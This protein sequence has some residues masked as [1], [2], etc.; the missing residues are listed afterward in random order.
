MTCVV[1][2]SNNR[3]FFCGLVVDNSKPFFFV[4]A[5]T[6]VPEQVLSLQRIFFSK[7]DEGVQLRANR[8]R[9][10]SDALRHLDQRHP[11]MSRGKRD[12]VELVTESPL[13]GLQ[14]HV[15]QDQQ[16]LLFLLSPSH[17][18]TVPRV[19]VAVQTRDDLGPPLGEHYHASVILEVQSH[20]L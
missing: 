2:Y 14:T 3:V 13:L 15:V 7:H 17:V 10:R 18:P 5:K 19:H 12:L 1:P 6:E 11:V 20:G 9:Q 16:A 4:F 8:G